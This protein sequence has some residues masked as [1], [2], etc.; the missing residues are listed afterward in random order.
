MPRRTPTLLIAMLA[1]VASAGCRRRPPEV[2]PP[3]PPPAAD[4]DLESARRDSI[5]RAAREQAERERLAQAER[6]RA[7]RI[8]QMTRAVEAP[9]YFG[10]DRS[11]LTDEAKAILDAKLAILQSSPALRVLIEGHAD[12]TGSDEYNLAL[13]HRRAEAAKRYLTDQG[14]DAG[15]LTTLSYGEERPAC[16]DANKSC[17]ARNRRAEFRITAGELRIE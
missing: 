14:L 9:S 15:R 12:E 10:F 3:L 4:I 6:E 11:D 7:N 17:Y 8:E 5:D 16:T 1:A 13:G 2:A